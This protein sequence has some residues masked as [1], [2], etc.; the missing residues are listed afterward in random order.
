ML[1]ELLD[2]VTKHIA[3]LDMKANAPAFAG[4][5]RRAI[6]SRREWRRQEP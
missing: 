1:F 6:S 5:M 4:E 2:K 3:S